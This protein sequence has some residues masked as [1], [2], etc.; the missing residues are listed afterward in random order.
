MQWQRIGLILWLVGCSGDEGSVDSGECDSGTSTETGTDT[1]S[2]SVDADNDGY[3][4]GEDCNDQNADVY[5]GATEIPYDSIDQDCDGDDL[6]DVDEDGFIAEIVGGDDCNDEDDQIHPMAEERKNNIDDNCDGAIDETF[7][8]HYDDWPAMIA[9]NNGQVFIEQIHVGAEGQLHVSGRFDGKPEFPIGGREISA[10]GT[11]EDIFLLRLNPDRDA[12]WVAGLSSG[13]TAHPLQMVV[14]G[15]ESVLVVGSYDEVL[16]FDIDVPTYT[17]TSNGGMDGFAG[18]YDSTGALTWGASFGGVDDDAAH[19]VSAD[20]AD[21]IWIGG[22]YGENHDFDPGAGSADIRETPGGDIGGYVLRL[23]YEGNYQSHFVF[24]GDIKK[25]NTAEVRLLEETETGL[26]LVGLFSGGIDMDPT[27]DG[28][29]WIQNKG[30]PAL[31]ALHMDTAGNL[32]WVLQMDSVGPVTPKRIQLQSDGS[33]YV[34]GTFEDSIDLDPGEGVQ[35]IES[36]GGIDSFV[37]QLDSQGQ[38]IQSM[39]LGSAGNDEIDNFDVHSNGDIFGAGSFDG[40]ITIGDTELVS[41][42]GHDCVVM[43][44]SFSD[45]PSWAYG[46]GTS[47]EERC[48]GV[49]L[50][51][52]EDQL[53]TGGWVSDFIHFEDLGWDYEHMMLGVHDGWLLHTPV[54]GP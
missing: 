5:P 11:T 33:F 7:Q 23:D 4:Y 28:E 39:H 8:A 52:A 1:Q 38:Y 2:P 6:I 36:E 3:P 41:Q 18:L 32:D 15:N 10:D 17:V 37:V 35:S 13:S 16:D 14:D 53:F 54:E 25:A 24:T 45:Q 12:E 43:R 27:A 40:T 48:P 46:L 26:L 50:N 34:L 19:A 21:A 49:Q 29:H 47:S 22:S 42:G 44:W 30:E 31:F 51:A 20:T 9:G